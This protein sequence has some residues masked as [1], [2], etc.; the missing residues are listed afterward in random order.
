LLLSLPLQQ[1]YSNQLLFSTAELKETAADI[2]SSGF[3]ARIAFEECIIGGRSERAS[4]CHA[5]LT[6]HLMY[7][8]TTLCIT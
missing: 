1:V 2:G 3:S 4:S 7:S 8:L 6:F 5:T